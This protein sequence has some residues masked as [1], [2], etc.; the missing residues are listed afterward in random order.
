MTTYNFKVIL[1]AGTDMTEELAD[2]LFEGVQ[3]HFA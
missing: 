3:P 1:A 2:Q